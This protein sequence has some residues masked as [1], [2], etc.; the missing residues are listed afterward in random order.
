[1]AS[2]P[3]ATTGRQIA[4]WKGMPCLKVVHHCPL[5]IQASRAVVSGAGRYVNLVAS[6]QV[7][8]PGANQVLAVEPEQGEL[9][10]IQILGPHRPSRPLL[11]GPRLQ[12]FAASAGSSEAS[13]TSDRPAVVFSRLV[14]VKAGDVIDVRTRFNLTIH[15]SVDNAPFT[16]TSIFLT[17]RR[18]ATFPNRGL[19]IVGRAGQNCPGTCSVG[20]VGAIRS[21]LSGR[22]YVNVAVV[23][24][25]H[26]GS[27]NATASYAGNLTVIKR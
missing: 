20:Q 18:T 9:Q 3:T 1:M 6:A 23:V 15:N 14:T 16:G 13:R 25:D 26:E 19:S 5:S 21:P 10:V 22:V 8:G 27:T 11:S 2:S 24:K 12:S 4:P 17:R 7:N